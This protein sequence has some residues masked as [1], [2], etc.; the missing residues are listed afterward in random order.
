MIIGHHH[1]CLEKRINAAL[2]SGN[3]YP[4]EAI[5]LHKMSMRLDEYGKNARL[6][7]AQTHYLFS[8][9][10]R[11]KPTSSPTP[12]KPPPRPRRSRP[13]PQ[14][15]QPGSFRIEDCF[16]DPQS[17]PRRSSTPTPP[18][19]IA[20]STPTPAPTH[21]APGALGP[22]PSSEQHSK[23]L[24][25][26]KPTNPPLS[27]PTTPSTD[28]LPWP[29]PQPVRR[30]AVPFDPRS[31][32]LP[33]RT[34]TPKALASSPP[35]EAAMR[36]WMTEHSARLEARRQHAQNVKEARERRWRRQSLNSGYCNPYSGNDSPSSPPS[37]ST[38]HVPNV[39][40]P[41]SSPTEKLSTPTITSNPDPHD[42][43]ALF[44]ESPERSRRLRDFR[45]RQEERVRKSPARSD[46]QY[47]PG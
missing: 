22:A 17:S 1:R 45:E 36:A 41:P 4:R 24:A 47:S 46:G 35:D 10:D 7:D 8:I 30:N 21:T 32:H 14:P 34:A 19:H 44:R 37:F 11:L 27:K 43:T 6:S 31:L 13:W 39:A 33:K 2:L 12:E 16:N 42:V 20:V 40:P 38:S 23:A 9:L 18:D 26:S 5:F 15:E 28:T 3:A 25:E 29:S